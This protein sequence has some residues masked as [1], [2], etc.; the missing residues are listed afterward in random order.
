MGDWIE[1]MNRSNGRARTS[2]YERRNK[3]KGGGVVTQNA[4]NRNVKDVVVWM[5]ESNLE[6]E[7]RIRHGCISQRAI[8]GWGVEGRLPISRPHD[9]SSHGAP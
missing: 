7:E 9:R 8:L 1:L 2:G 6:A 3:Q 5:W 4:R